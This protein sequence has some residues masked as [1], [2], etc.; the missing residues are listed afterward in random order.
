MEK[1][2]HFPIVIVGGGP[3]GI[4]SAIQLK[5]Y[6]LEPV[7]IERKRV[8]GLLWNA[9]RV[10]NMPG[11]F[12]GP[13]GAKLAKRLEEHLSMYSVRVIRGDVRELDYLV[14]GGVFFLDTGE[15]QYTADLVVLASGTR[16]K[17]ELMERWLQGS[18]KLGEAE[19]G[20]VIFEV[21]ELSG[22]EGL[23][24][25]VAGAGDAALDYA[26]SLGEE[27][28]NRVTIFHRS[29]E[30]RALP[31]LQREV[32]KREN[33]SML[34]PYTIKRIER[35]GVRPLAI[36]LLG[37][38]DGDVVGLEADFFLCAWGRVPE[39]EFYSSGMHELEGDL[40]KAGRLYLVGDVKNGFCRQVAIAL[41]NGIEVAM[42]VG[43][44]LYGRQ[45]KKEMITW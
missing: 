9:Y 18:E 41:G 7:I 17:Y 33:I 39:K 44:K 15:A 24:V 23:R 3:G 34:Y 27:R 30:I 8:G 14:D 21:A 42:Q 25:V 4:A 26:L 5:R 37:E 32:E 31:L 22:L 12:P 28:T 10:E 19:R 38:S 35:G 16:P 6:D 11:I 45:D 1:R 2:E 13:G 43:M 36:T 29:G 40:I 20:R